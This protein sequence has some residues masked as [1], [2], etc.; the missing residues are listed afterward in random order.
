MKV[1]ITGTTGMVGKGVLIECIKSPAISSIFLINRKPVNIK[2]DKITEIIH[3]DFTDLD[4]LSDYFK[5][6]DG[7]FFCLGV[8]SIGMKEEKFTK[9]T[10]FLFAQKHDGVGLRRLNG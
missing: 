2:S 9:I 5:E 3:Q 4:S 6:I 8:S 1:L 10:F 7:C